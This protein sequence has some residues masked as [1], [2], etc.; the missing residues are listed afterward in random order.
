MGGETKYPSATLGAS[1]L[2]LCVC[3]LRLKFANLACVTSLAH[4][5][6]HCP[7]R[8]PADGGETQPGAEKGS[9]LW[10]DSAIKKKLKKIVM[11]LFI[12][13]HLK[14]RQIATLWQLFSQVPE[15]CWIVAFTV[16]LGQILNSQIFKVILHE[17]QSDK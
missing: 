10:S 6:S 7:P 11:H 5:A 3:E 17:N 9:C 4:E 12:K 16:L 15:C 14:I 1:Q 2:W 8:Q 13:M